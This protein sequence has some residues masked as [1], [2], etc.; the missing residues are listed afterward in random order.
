MAEQLMTCQDSRGKFRW[1]HRA[2]N[3]R[4]DDASEQGYR[5]KWYATFKARRRYPGLDVVHVGRCV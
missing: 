2:G 1:S 5:W 3:N 4:I